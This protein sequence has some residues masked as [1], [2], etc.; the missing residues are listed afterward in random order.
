M[1]V[2]RIGAVELAANTSLFKCVDLAMDLSAARSGEVEVLADGIKVG[3]FTGGQR[4]YPPKFE[5]LRSTLN[6]RELVECAIET[7]IESCG[8]DIAKAAELLGVGK[9]T[10]YRRMKSRK[11]ALVLMR[12]A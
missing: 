11:P 9:T 3:G 6:I 2:I 12:A 1:N 10:L 7:A 8:G 5:P 4:T